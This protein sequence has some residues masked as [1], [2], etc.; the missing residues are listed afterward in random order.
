M[1]VDLLNRLFC[2]LRRIVVVWDLISPVFI[3]KYSVR[4]TTRKLLR[5]TPKMAMKPAR[6]LPMGVMGEY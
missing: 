6:N 1:L 2:S 3:L 5:M 4:A